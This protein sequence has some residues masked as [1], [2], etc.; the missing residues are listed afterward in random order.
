MTDTSVMG[1]LSLVTL[2]MLARA[3][4]PEVRAT[5]RESGLVVVILV[6]LAIAGHLFLE[7]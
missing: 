1:I 3:I 2:A 6:G 7:P 5:Y 4:A